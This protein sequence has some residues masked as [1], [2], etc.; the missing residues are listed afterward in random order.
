MHVEWNSI[1]CRQDVKLFWK[2]DKKYGLSGSKTIHL[3][4]NIFLF[5]SICEILCKV[6]TVKICVASTNAASLPSTGKRD[7]S[8]IG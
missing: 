6:L 8:C 4:F 2:T 3:F 5:M 7:V 1:K